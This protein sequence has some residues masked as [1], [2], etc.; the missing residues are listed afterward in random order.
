M[1]DTGTLLM[2]IVTLGCTARC[3]HCC[4]AAE[5]EKAYLRLTEKEMMQYIEKACEVGIQGVVFTGG[6]PTVYLADLYKPMVLARALGLYT[7]L[8]T[9][10]HWAKSKSKALD[11]LKYLWNC[12]LERLG[13]SY[14]TYHQQYIPQ[15][16]VLNAI[17]ATQT[18]GMELYLDWIGFE[19]ME[20][21][22]KQLRIDKSVVRTITPPLRIGAA[23]ELPDNHFEAIPIEEIECDSAFSQSCGTGEPPLL[24]VFPGGYASYH[25]CCWVNPRLVYKMQSR[26]WIDSLKEQTMQDSAVTF[27]K[28]HGISG[29]IKKAKVECSEYLKPY[30][31][32]QCEVCY[33]LLSVLFPRDTELPWY[34]EGLAKDIN[35]TESLSLVGVR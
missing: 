35:S 21:V 34:L 6:E 9:N 26:H 1:K 13:L 14:D 20:E 7:D 11:T 3:A 16:Y 22:T 15:E 29:L 32:H 18:L 2:L 17:E 24:T 5:P 28:E 12:G 27:L 30:Y 4:L 23:V 33:D 19:T 8:R 10:A 25:Q 31:S